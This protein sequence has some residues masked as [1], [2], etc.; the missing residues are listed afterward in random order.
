MYVSMYERLLKIYL[1]LNIGLKIT[2]KFFLLRLQ[3]IEM[4]TLNINNICNNYKFMCLTNCDK[5][6]TLYE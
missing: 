4:F 5:M 1:V 2:R 3:S 6:I